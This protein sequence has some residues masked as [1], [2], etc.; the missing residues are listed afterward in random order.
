MPITRVLVF[1]AIAAAPVVAMA[2][3]VNL[4]TGHATYSVSYNGGSTST[5]V[6]TTVNPAW[7]AVIPGADWIGPTSDSGTTNV[8]NGMYVYTTPFT[9]TSISDLTGSFASDNGASVYLSGGSLGSPILLG[10]NSYSG[11]GSFTTPTALLP[12]VLGPGSYILTVDLENGTGLD[13][14]SDNNS[15]FG[16]SG[17]LLQANTVSATPEPSSLAL[18][19]TGLL[20][21]AGIARRRLF[22]R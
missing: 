18:L 16:P 21:A 11:G 5:A 15:D 7:T 17:L 12:E 3:D 8:A 2:D 13:T 1:L 9:L 6:D 20:G 4:S 10:A 19:G 14:G 22:S